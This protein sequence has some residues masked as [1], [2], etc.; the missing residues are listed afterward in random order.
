MNVWRCQNNSYRT[1]ENNEQSDL[2]VEIS[3]Y[4]PA[5]S[6]LARMVV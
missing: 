6:G 2:K 1:I 4:I 5:A 3:R